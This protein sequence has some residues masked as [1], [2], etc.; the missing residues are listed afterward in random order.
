MGNRQISK[1]RQTGIKDGHVF[2]ASLVPERTG[3][4]ALAQAA[5][6]DDEQIAPLGDPAAA[7]S[8][9]WPPRRSKIMATLIAAARSRRRCAR[10]LPLGVWF[11]RLFRIAPQ[12]SSRV[13]SNSD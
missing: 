8:L 11:G 3:Q 5:G 7:A 2:P 12:T 13:L 6:A 10:S 9:L 4:P 1:P